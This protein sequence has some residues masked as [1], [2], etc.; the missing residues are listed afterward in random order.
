MTLEF[1]EEKHE[2]RI[3][4]VLLPNV[5]RITNMM[6]SY[7][8]VPA[9]VLAAKAEIGQA[10][11]WATELDDQDDLD[12][13]GL[14][15]ELRGYV[16]AWR[17]FK[18]QTGWITELSEQRVYSKRYQF[19]G[20]LDCIGHFE[21]LAKVRPSV[22]ALIDKKTT[23]DILPSVGPQVAAYAEAWNETNTPK[24]RRRFA[25]QLKRDGFYNLHECGDATDW[26]VFLSGLTLSNWLKRNHLEINKHERID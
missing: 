25:V 10:V 26:S 21:S 1:N 14:P 19:A 17:L 6:S 16:D 2:Y 7:A 8:G 20:T 23:Y 3:D 18:K 9:S 5:T 12:Y 15:D 24:I 22:L 13:L 4:G 11:H